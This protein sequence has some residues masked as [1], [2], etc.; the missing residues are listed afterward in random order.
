VL[1][2]HNMQVVMGVCEELH[3]LDHGETIAHGTPDHVRK[4]PRCSPP[5]SAKAP[6]APPQPQAEAAS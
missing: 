2:E 6:E 3:V 1:V 4:I 5:T